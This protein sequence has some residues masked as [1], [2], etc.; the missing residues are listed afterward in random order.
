M[1]AQSLLL[2]NKY[3]INF[4]KTSLLSTMCP[5]GI[6]IERKSYAAGDEFDRYSLFTTAHS[7]L[8]RSIKSVS[9]SLAPFMGTSWYPKALTIMISHSPIFSDFKVF[10]SDMGD[11][12]SFFLT[13]L[14]LCLKLLYRNN[15]FRQIKK[16]I[17][18]LCDD[19]ARI[20]DW[21][22]RVNKII[23]E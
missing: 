22:Q 1:L 19:K 12:P 23:S 18:T 13:K 9:V 8:A 2:K 15:I 16:I 6:M 5:R 7:K 11:P 20:K 4:K 10:F 3:K 17:L 21:G 14:M